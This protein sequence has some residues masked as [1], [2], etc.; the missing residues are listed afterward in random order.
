VTGGR[1][2]PAPEAGVTT[3]SPKSSPDGRRIVFY[4][5]PTELTF[6]ARIQEAQAR[7]T[8]QIVSVDVASG[9]RTVYA[10]GPGLTV[11][12]QFLS[13]DR[14]GY[15]V[16]AAPQPAQTGLASTTGAAAVGGS[17]RSP[18]WSSGRNGFT[19][20]SAWEDSMPG[21]VP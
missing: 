21:L 12:P 6:A 10:S 17:F 15:R 8:S 16:K 14:I 4:E 2:L 3:G 18:A 9:A 13:A 5:V 11:S 20:E 1:T 19:D 7:V